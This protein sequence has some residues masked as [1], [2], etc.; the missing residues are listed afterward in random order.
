MYSRQKLNVDKFYIK[1][2]NMKG[3]VILLLSI[4]TITVTAQK[5]PPVK[6][7]GYSSC[8]YKSGDKSG[9]FHSSDAKIKIY[10]TDT[11]TSKFIIID[12]GK[13]ETINITRLVRSYTNY[14][15][16]TTTGGT[17]KIIYDIYEGVSN[18][19]NSMCKI[20]W[21]LFDQTVDGQDAVITIDYEDYGK[22]FKLRGN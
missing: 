6:Y 2:I 16:L 17:T 3:V 12:K 5:Y 8:T 9:V 1:F 19:T 7:T 4:L 18:R 13:T 15:K 22:V 21:G 10:I 11:T 14:F 20:T